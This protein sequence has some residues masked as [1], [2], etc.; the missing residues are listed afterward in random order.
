MS[1][2]S[3]MDGT[4]SKI[5]QEAAA[6]FARRRDGVRT[7]T[8][9]AAFEAWHLQSDAHARAYADTERAW[10]QWQS[11]QASSRMREM[12]AAA[13]ATTAPK[14]RK[15]AGLPWRP[16]LLAASVAVV[17]IIG[18]GQLLPLFAPK[19]MPVAYGTQ[20]G[21]QRSEWLADG[22]RITLNTQ[23][24]LEVRYSRA[25]R[26]IVLK[27][28]EVMF[29]VAHDAE[30]PFVVSA[31][32]GTVTAL[33]TQFQVREESRTAAVTLL[34]G[35]VEVALAAERKLLVP[36][37]QATYG[38]AGPGIRVRQVD[39]AAVS[40]WTQG[41]LDFSGLPLA[42]AVAEANR[43]STVKLRL[44]DP[45]LADLPVGGS[46]RIGDNAAI[47]SA[48]SLVFP[49]QVASSNDHEIVLMPRN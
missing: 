38:S 17:A 6:W 9:E 19:A 1:V 10:Q 25:Q 46:F 12:A 27:R 2:N 24:E 15:R 3:S 5:Q 7:R 34:Q 11:L 49:V 18:F 32:G 31:G 28:G 4:H 43:Y 42:E 23:T 37:D 14:R 8:E 26:D 39:P 44:G 41:R 35:S 20:L 21:E 45:A 13:M 30:R 29:E 33:G 48:F 47:A 22:T 36:G 40:G 16:L